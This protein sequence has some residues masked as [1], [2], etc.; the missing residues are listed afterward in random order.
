MRARR[1]VGAVHTAGVAVRLLTWEE[2]PELARL[3]PAAEDVWPEYNLHGDVFDERW[4]ALPEELPESR[5][6]GHR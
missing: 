4:G 5:T 2:H 3:G 1:Y 6:R